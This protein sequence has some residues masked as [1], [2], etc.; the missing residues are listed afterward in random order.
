[1]LALRLLVAAA[2]LAVLAWRGCDACASAWV[3][4]AWMLLERLVHAR[5]VAILADMHDEARREA[6]RIRRLLADHTTLLKEVRQ[7]MA[8][9]PPHG[10]AS[11]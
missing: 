5:D 9:P 2:A 11:P 8:R 1:M 6:R 4:A 10:D 7:S 3:L